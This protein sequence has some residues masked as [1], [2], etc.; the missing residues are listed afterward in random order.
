M[1]QGASS[2]L[3]KR[4]GQ[5]AQKYRTSNCCWIWEQ[6]VRPPLWNRQTIVSRKH[7]KVNDSRLDCASLIC[8][9]SPDKTTQPSPPIASLPQNLQ[10]RC[11]LCSPSPCSIETRDRDSYRKR[12]C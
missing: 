9:A 5:I 7:P 1:E 10:R 6:S 3:F 4:Y 2:S 12:Y 11:S 8:S